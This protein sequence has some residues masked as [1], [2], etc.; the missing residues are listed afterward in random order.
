MVRSRRVYEDSPPVQ[1][2]YSLEAGY[3]ALTDS[4]SESYCF[5]LPS[6][7]LLYRLDPFLDCRT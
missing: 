7:A 3:K 2:P 4:Y 5:A 1:M 6:V